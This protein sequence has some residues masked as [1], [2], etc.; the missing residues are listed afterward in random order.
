MFGKRKHQREVAKV[1]A[2]R[3]KSAELVIVVDADLTHAHGPYTSLKQA[4]QLCLMESA[5]SGKP[6]TVIPFEFTTGVVVTPE[7]IA[8]ALKA[9]KNEHSDVDLNRGYL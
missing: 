7:E 6:H 9:N 1:K 8:G 4:T 3:L 2:L 5:K